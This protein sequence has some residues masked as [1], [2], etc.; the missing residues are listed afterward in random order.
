M[1]LLKSEKRTSVEVAEV[2]ECREMVVNNWLVRYEQEGPEGLQT[3]LNCYSAVDFQIVSR[4]DSSL[5]S[6]RE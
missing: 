3:R 2:L 6:S 5:R 4:I 1:V